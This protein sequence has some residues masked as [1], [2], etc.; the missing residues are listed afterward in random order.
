MA[1][2]GVKYQALIEDFQGKITKLQ[3]ELNASTDEK[4]R[5]RLEQELFQMR[6]LVLNLA[7]FPERVFCSQYRLN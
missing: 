5:A 7:V 1:R 6:E 4:E 3:E 2:D